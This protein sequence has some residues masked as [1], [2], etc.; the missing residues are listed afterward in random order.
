MDCGSHAGKARGGRVAPGVLAELA[1]AGSG[2]PWH[3]LGQEGKWRPAAVCLMAPLAVQA[4]PS[5]RQQQQVEADRQGCS[6][7]VKRFYASC[8]P[9]LPRG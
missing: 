7:K 3:G 5:P 9:K 6:G 8:A 4:V 1:A 2:A